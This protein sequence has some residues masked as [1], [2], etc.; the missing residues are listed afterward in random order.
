M[1][2]DIDRQTAAFVF[3]FADVPARSWIRKPTLGAF[4][5]ACRDCQDSHTI[6]D[7]TAAS[8]ILQQ[9]VMLYVLS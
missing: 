5:A 2:I 1:T 7:T 8:C 3:S 4:K 6:A 9:M